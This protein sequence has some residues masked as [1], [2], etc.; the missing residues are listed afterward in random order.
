MSDDSKKLR[1]GGMAL[2]NGLLVHGPTHWAAAIRAKDGE[3]KVASGRKLDLGGRAFARVPGMRGVSRLAEAVAVIPAVKRQLP[4]AGL[5]ME[6]VRVLG[7]MALA[8]GLSRAVRNGGERTA[9][10]EALVSMLGMAP[11]LIMLHGGE[12]AAY[13]GAE[14]KAIGAYEQ[15]LDAAEATREHDRC[16]TNLAV[17][18]IA[19]SALGTAVARRAG[20][21]GSAA[22]AAGALGGMA[23]AVEVFAWSERHAG[24]KLAKAL[25]RPGYEFQRLVGTREPTAQQL[26]VGR[27][28]LNE[29]L[30]VES[31]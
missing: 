17:P 1:L 14:H 30:R 11:A 29:I 16:G 4:E 8:A 6:D 26:D 15:G 21:R 20:M 13:H 25:K 18:L 12:I 27:A 19:T 9:G 2:Q 22:D 28:A 10:R 24:T 3:I 31:S 23:I 7:S 5:P